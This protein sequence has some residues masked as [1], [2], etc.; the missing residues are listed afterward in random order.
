MFLPERALL[1]DDLRAMTSI[2]RPSASGGEAKAAELL[3]ASLREAGGEVSLEHDRVVGNYWLPLGLLSVAGLGAGALAATGRARPLAALLGVGAAAGVW[4]DVTAQWRWIRKPLPKRQTTNVLAWFG[5][6]DAER[7]IVLVAHHDAAKSGLIFAP[8]IPELAWRIAPGYME[9]NDDGPPVMAPVAAAPALAALAAIA[10]SRKLG[11]AA[12]GL[13]ALLTSI[14]S[15]IAARKTVEGAN[16]NATGVVT[17]Q[18]LARRLGREPTQ[19]TRVL[20]LSTGSEESLLEGMHGFAKRWFPKLDPGKTFFLGVDTVGSGELCVLHGEGML[21]MRDYPKAA[22]SL[23]EEEADRLGLPLVKGLRHRNS[24][25]ALYPLQAGYMTA[26]LGSVNEM[27]L[28]GNYHWK[29]DTFENVD[30]NCLIDAVELCE[31]VIRRLDER[32][33]EQH[34]RA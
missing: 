8:Q 19:K 31:A 21:R 29:S 7:T 2:H 27:K 20:L 24:T 26:M 16:D 32:W 22:V 28:P 4:G 5:P 11:L 30:I 18:A 9:R 13:A 15:D 12:A 1:E 6:A 17:L 33:L 10:G 25:D 34:E 3:A 14:F 23:L